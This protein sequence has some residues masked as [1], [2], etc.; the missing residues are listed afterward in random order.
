[1][2][3]LQSVTLKDIATR[4]GVSAMTVSVVLSGRSKNVFV[5][6]ATRQRV[7]ALAQ[8]MGYRP[9]SAARALATGRTYLVEFWAQSVSNPYF[10]AVYHLARRELQSYG[11]AV[12]LVELVGRAAPSD[13]LPSCSADGLLVFDWPIG[14]QKLREMLTAN[15]SSHLPFVS[16]GCYRVE[17]ADYVGVDLYTGTLEAVQHLLSAGCRR[18]AHLVDRASHYESEPRRRAYALAVDQAA[19]EPEY[20]IAPDA[21]RASARQA[22]REHVR[23]RGC[24]EGLF[25]HNDIL[26]VG[27]Y[28]GLCELG[29]RVPDDI[30]LVGC[31]GIEEIEYLERPLS[32]LVQ[33]AQEMCRRACRF[34]HERINDPSLPP[35]QALLKAELVIRAS[36]ARQPSG[37]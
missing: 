23:T 14:G 22:L 26:A 28:R 17:E 33:P 5:S 20:V 21:S 11:L 19:Q 24:P 9:N 29:L 27:A 32:T 8:E 13:P 37:E 34:L 1:M 7:L 25:C 18:I 16:M 12:S 31:D 10:N 4:A 2:S 36:S 30:A 6:E 3:R 35:Q 15:R